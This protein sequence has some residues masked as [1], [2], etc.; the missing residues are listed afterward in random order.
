MIESFLAVKCWSELTS[1]A[2]KALQK[3]AWGWCAVRK[4]LPW[5]SVPQNNSFSA[6]DGEKVAGGRM[7]AV[8]LHPMANDGIMP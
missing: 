3:L 1:N 7:D 4:H 6:S 2:L 5:K 8:G